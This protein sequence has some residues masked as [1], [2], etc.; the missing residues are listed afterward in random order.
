M[1]SE[2]NKN[3]KNLNN[4]K[5][6]AI[7]KLE[8]EIV[9]AEIIKTSFNGTVTFLELYSYINDNLTK[10]PKDRTA[11]LSIGVFNNLLEYTTDD[12]N[13]AKEKALLLQNINKYNL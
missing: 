2:S 13:D 1:Q 10:Y 9:I 6:Y 7:L 8:D 12:I 11:N 3:Y 4:L 5:K